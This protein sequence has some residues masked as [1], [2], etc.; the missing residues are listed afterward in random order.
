[1]AKKVSQIRIINPVSEKPTKLQPSVLYPQE[2]PVL[3]G[4]SLGMLPRA[5]ARLRLAQRRDA[6]QEREGGVLTG[7]RKSDGGEVVRAQVAQSM[8]SGVTRVWV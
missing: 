1:M 4:V 2:E 8:G 6:E 5:E 7:V 3:R